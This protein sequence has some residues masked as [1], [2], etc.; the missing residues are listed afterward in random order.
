MPL[1]VGP[2]VVVVCQRPFEK[3]SLSRGTKGMMVKVDAGDN[4]MNDYWWVSSWEP[5][6]IASVSTLKEG[7]LIEIKGVLRKSRDRLTINLT[8]CPRL[9]EKA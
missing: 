1:L 5:E 8:E 4:G 9:L 3:E 7:D 6:G 2:Q